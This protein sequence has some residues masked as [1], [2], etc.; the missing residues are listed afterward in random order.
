[1]PQRDGTDA[2]SEELR[3][4]YE[5]RFGNRTGYR[6][7]VW[8]TLTRSFF[9]EWI[10]PS[11]AVLDLGCGYGEFINNVVAARRIAMD[12]NPDIKVRVDSDVEVHLHDCTQPWPVEPGSLDVVFTSNF[13]EHLMTRD[14]IRRAIEHA[15]SALR[16]GGRLIA[17]GPNVR[18]VP[19]VYW[20]FF[21]H[22]IP[23]TERSV[24]E[25]VEDSGFHIIECVGSFLPYTIS[26]GREYPMWMLEAYLKLPA[27]WRFVGKQFLVVAERR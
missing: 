7:R 17:M 23:L 4:M 24:S 1:M 22:Q 5:R 27:I 21:D 3:R 26:D 16:P 8:Q 11:S 18:R 12:L 9:S 6:D 13:L 2:R 20:D 14:E 15:H 10:L 19:G 25:V